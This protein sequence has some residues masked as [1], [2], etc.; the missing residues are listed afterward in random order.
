MLRTMARED[1]GV[2]LRVI[3]WV[4]LLAVLAGGVLFVYVR[5]QEPLALDAATVRTVGTGDDPEA[6]RLRQGARIFVAAFL[7]N[8]GRM[9]VTVQGL[10]EQDDPS[11]PF[12]PTAIA[13]GD[14]SSTTAGAAAP[15]TP[16]TVDPGEGVGILMT[17]E[18]NPDLDCSLYSKDAGEAWPLRRV[19]LKATAYLMP[20]DQTVTAEV[21]F[22][23]I[24][25][26][27]RE[28]CLAVTG[29]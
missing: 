15:F 27:T 12:I 24:E 28:Q 21:P 16:I 9:P 1:G 6:P 25:G 26:P 19:A 11:A 2:V 18:V 4:A 8:E 22:A 13:L 10:A 5:L 20:F 7:R 23:R 3:L 29:A 17:F 14:G